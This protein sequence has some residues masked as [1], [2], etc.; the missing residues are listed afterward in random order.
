M[1]SEGP[2]TKIVS[3][4][5]LAE[6]EPEPCPTPSNAR[7]TIRRER[8]MKEVSEANNIYVRNMVD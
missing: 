3:T 8:M 7:H 2:L 6:P 1:L 4:N 5:N